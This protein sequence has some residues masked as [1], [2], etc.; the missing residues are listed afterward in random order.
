LKTPRV[1]VLPRDRGAV[2]LRRAENLL[3]VMEVADAA[4]NPD[5]IVI[6]AVQAAIALGDAFTVSLVQRRSRGQDHSEV[7]LLVKLCPS[8]STPEVV[9]LIQSLLNR[10]SEILYGSQEVS[11][12][13]ARQLADLARKLYSVV[14]S[15]VSPGSGGPRK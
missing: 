3:K 13:Q 5:G 6:N 9:R 11:L 2:Y 8:P 12:R 10:R 15:A 14:R 7:L 4:A 1:E